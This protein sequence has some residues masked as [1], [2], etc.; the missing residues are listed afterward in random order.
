MPK[1]REW[2]IRLWQTLWPGRNGHDLEEELRLH[3]DLATEDARRGSDSPETAARAA[4]VREGGLDPALEAVRD[5]HRV[6]WLSDLG[7]DLRYAIRVLVRRPVPTAAAVIT[8]A[9]GLGAATAVFSVLEAAI[10]RPLSH[11]ELDRMVVLRHGGEREAVS[12]V[13]SGP[14]FRDWESEAQSF[15]ALSAVQTAPMR[16]FVSGTSAPEQVVVARVSQGFFPV[17][18]IQVA[19]GRDFRTADGLA[20]PDQVAVISHGFWQ[21]HFGDAPTVLGQNLTIRGRSLTIIGILRS[22]FFLTA[23]IL[24]PLEFDAPFIQNRAAQRLQVVGRLKPAVTVEQ[25]QAEMDTLASRLEEAYPEAN[26]G[27]GVRVALLMEQQGNSYFASRLWIT[28][29]AVGFVLLIGCLNVANLQL[30]RLDERRQELDLHRALGAGQRRLVWQLLTEST[31]LATAG[32]GGGLLVAVGTMRA[33]VALAPAPL[34]GSSPPT[35]NLTVFS[36]LLA[37]TVVTILVV[38]LLPALRVVR[39]RGI[40]SLSV[41]RSLTAGTSRRRLRRGLVASQAA[42][43]VVLLIGAGSLLQDLTARS[44]A[45]LGF[46]AG[47]KL[48]VRVNLPRPQYQSMPTRMDYLDTARNQLLR[49]P[50]VTGVAAV[51]FVPFDRYVF[52]T[53]LWVE[54]FEEHPLRETPAVQFRT[55][56]A[57]YFRVM[58][59]PVLA[60][61]SFDERDDVGAPPVLIVNDG[62]RRRLFGEASGLDQQVHLNIWN[63]TGTRAGDP[64]DPSGT[65]VGVVGDVRDRMETDPRLRVYLPYRQHTDSSI[66]FVVSRR[67]PGTASVRNIHA[68]LASVDPLVEPASTDTLEQMVGR[69]LVDPRFFASLLTGFALVALVLAAVG[70]YGVLAQ[71]VTQ[72]A[73]EFAIRIALGAQLRDVRWII[74]REASWMSVGGLLVGL[75][76]AAGLHGLLE[77]FVVSENLDL[78]QVFLL[79]PLVF[80]G[81]VGLAVLSPIRRAARVNPAE[82]LRAE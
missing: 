80:V 26:D 42:L 81:V 28:F 21:R 58:A 38:G 73:R 25:A 44:A 40:S 51:N 66:A 63:P 34:I 20:D 17:F 52:N 9:I 74:A 60:G 5:Q 46:D 55:V 13:V 37:A 48:T 47:D 30:A 64:L 39:T 82:A 41:G 31:L 18:G 75:G 2:L 11:P 76:A 1:L 32:V 62:L 78:P 33:I 56:T 67:G 69:Q 19:H 29:S 72:R 50:G 61:R 8:L 45:P 71:G 27:L 12:S 79:G 70:L 4:R 3:L 14:N 54:G 10:L 43:S 49:L 24:V 36:F 16:P 35:L 77:S 68:V 53:H 59:I 15:E 7:R 57:D 6:P 23:D 65:V 22:D